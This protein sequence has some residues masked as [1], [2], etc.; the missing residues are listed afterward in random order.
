ME[1]VL[2]QGREVGRRV[3]ELFP[4]GILLK[5]GPHRLAEAREATR[6]AV[7]EGAK[8]LF[9][10]SFLHGEAMAR[11]DILVPNGYDSWDP[12]EV[13]ASTKVKPEHLPDLA[14]QVQGCEGACLAVRRAVLLHLNRDCRYPDL[15]N[16]L[17][18][19]DLSEPVR[20]HLPELG[21]NLAGFQALPEQTQEPE[22][23]LGTHCFSPN[24]CP[25]FDYCVRL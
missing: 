19:E 25:F 15:S 10:A 6:K 22:A 16:L 5:E 1:R 21:E 2:A 14:F 23:R 12:L 8:V 18:E 24:D 11:T 20:R 3:R 4:G 9:E 7:G 17:R 13:K